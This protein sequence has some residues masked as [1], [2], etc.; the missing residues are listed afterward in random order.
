MAK[1]KAKMVRQ[2]DILLVPEKPEGDQIRSPV[3][4]VEGVGGVL[5]TGLATGHTHRFPEVKNVE[6]FALEG[7]EDM[8]LVVKKA[9]KLVH[10]QH[11]E[12]K[13]EA[14][15]YTVR[16]QRTLTPQGAQQVED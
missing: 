2:G 12:I 13:V 3:R 8:E 9:T 16:R 10:D 7:L 11:K 5:A 15:T 4:P 6:L 1:A 14:G